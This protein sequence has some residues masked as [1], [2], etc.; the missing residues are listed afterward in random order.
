MADVPW[1]SEEGLNYLCLHSMIFNVVRPGLRKFFIREWNSRYQTSLGAWDDTIVSGGQLFHHE[2]SRKSPNVKLY[3]P[4]FLH[5]D[6]S[7][8]EL[9]V[10]FD[11]I[12][13]SNSIGSTLNPTIRNAVDLLR[14]I[15]NRII[16]TGEA[17]LTDAEFQITMNDVEYSFKVLGLSTDDITSIRSKRNLYKPFE[18]LPPKPT[19]EVVGMYLLNILYRKS[20]V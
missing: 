16:H 18:I 14:K 9:S 2:K 3:R 11:A 20:R 8:W 12:L 17:R 7:Q 15:R 10:L 1:E 4:S 19:H 5:G 13:Y 6:T